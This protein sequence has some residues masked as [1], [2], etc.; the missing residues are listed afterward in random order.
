[1]DT[2][3]R[4]PPACP[5]THPAVLAAFKELRRC[6]IGKGLP[7]GLGGL[8]VWGSTGLDVNVSEGLGV[9]AE[10]QV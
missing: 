2:C 1:M 3:V 4:S 5:E 9:R 8:G 10:G 7:T 6:D